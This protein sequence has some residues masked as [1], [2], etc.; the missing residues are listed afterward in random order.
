[1]ARPCGPCQ[2]KRR[3]E[4]DRRLLEMD[5]TG[6][7]Y[8]SISREW[9][10][11]EDSL[12]RHK[13]NHIAAVVGD[14][15][16]IMEQARIEALEEARRQE[17]EEVKAEVVA[18]AKEGLAA[19]LE[20]CRDHFD[21]L[22]ILRERAAL[23]LET[24]EASEDL[25]VALQAIRELKDL[26]RLWAELEGKL[27]SQPQINLQQVNIYTSPEWDA[28]GLLLARILEDHPGL[29]AE[30]AEGLIALQEGRNEP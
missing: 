11:S 16:A 28:V 3:N 5:L 14:I 29:R 2:D 12:R 6:E 27:Q 20:L 25:K 15:K 19:R 10:Y 9:G 30:V 24:A 26:V 21:Q 7:T 18:E 4:L 8:V 1:M 13:T 17:M 23:A 22:R